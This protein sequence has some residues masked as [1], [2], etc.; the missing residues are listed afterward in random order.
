MSNIKLL[1]CTL[2]DGG[3][4]IEC[5]FGRKRISNILNDLQAS[6]I[7]IIEV[8][9]IRDKILYKQG[10]TFFTDFDQI[11]EYVRKSSSELVV[12]VDFGMYDIKRIPVWTEDNPITGIRYGFTKGNYDIA[13]EEMREIK[14]KGYKLFVQDVNTLGYS[15]GELLGLV[16]KINELDPYSFAIVDTYGAMY[17]EDVVRYFD[18]LNHNLNA[19]ICIDFH[20]HNNYQLSFAHAQK[21]I[22]LAKATDRTV[23]IDSTLYGMGKVAGNLNT[24]LVVEY[25]NKKHGTNYELNRIF[26]CIDENILEFKRNHEWGYSTNALL[27]G[28][29]MSHPNNV[30]YLTEKFK[31]DTTD[32]GKILSMI[33]D[34]KRKAYDYDNIERLYIQYNT[35]QNS[36]IESRKQIAERVRDKNVL[37]V[38]PGSSVAHEEKKVK[39]FIDEMEPVIFSVNFPYKMNKDGYAFFANTKRYKEFCNEIDTNVILLSNVKSANG[40]ELTINYGMLVERGEKNFDNATIMLLRLLKDMKMKALYIVGFDGFDAKGE[41]FVSEEMEF[42]SRNRKPEKINREIMSMFSRLRGEYK[43]REIEIKFITE[44][45]Y[46]IY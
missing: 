33:E 35:C 28:M 26:D 25:L 34:D 1:D 18:M 45:I 20:S 5:D 6:G 12:F 31:L 2:R 14:R 7:E 37:I 46:D 21:V 27:S 36:D 8:G 22:E 32:I 38:A 23:I 41:N 30:I 40:K 17:A 15:D 42:N 43:R 3:R 24:E 16:D 10:T 13:V 39:K 4:V 44:S 19:D 11:K 29:F 9:F